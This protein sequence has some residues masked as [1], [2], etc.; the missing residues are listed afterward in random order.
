M[1][2]RVFKARLEVGKTRTGIKYL[3]DAEKNGQRRDLEGE[4][5]K[6]SDVMHSQ[7]QPT[8]KLPE[9]Q[10]AVAKNQGQPHKASI[11]NLGSVP[12]GKSNKYTQL[13]NAQNNARTIDLKKGS[14]TKGIQTK[15]TQK[16]KTQ[17][18]I[19]KDLLENRRGKGSIPNT[20]K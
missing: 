9:I 15:S 7:R 8:V 20:G 16:V 6:V 4:K 12:I 17:Q 14:L 10:Y 2:E 19:Q 18:E 11:Q 3:T 13:A 5:E 1:D